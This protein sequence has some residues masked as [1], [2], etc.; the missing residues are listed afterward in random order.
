MH[1]CGAAI[2]T[3]I[4]AVSSSGIEETYDGSPSES[5]VPGRSEVDIWMYNMGTYRAF[6][7]LLLNSFTSRSDIEERTIQ[8]RTFLLYRLEANENKA[9]FHFYDPERCKFGQ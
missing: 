5:T 1:L 3:Y 2:I 9:G 8:H 4:H 6:A 7:A